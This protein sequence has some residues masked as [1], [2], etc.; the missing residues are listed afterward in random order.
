[1]PMQRRT[2][3]GRVNRPKVCFVGS[4]VPRACGIATFTSDLR[5][6]VANT[7]AASSVVALTNTDTGYDYPAEVALEIRQHQL[8]DY[9]LAAEYINDSDNDI[10]CLQHEFGIF[11]G[12]EG[13]YILDLLKRLRKPIVTTLHTV[14]P[15]PTPAYR[16]ALIGVASRSDHLVV[17]NSRAIPI[18]T[19]VYGIDP[20][21]I[22]MIHHGVPD[23]P[24]IDPE[25]F[26]DEFGVT[27]RT[28]LLTFGLLNRNKGIEQVLDALPCVAQ[29]HPDV[30]YL[31]LGATHPEVKRHDGE[32][33][34]YYLEQLVR[35]RGIGRHVQFH[36]YFV[37][38]DQL[39][40][41]IGASDIYIT[42]YRARDQIVSGTLAYAVGMGKAVVSTPYLYALELLS[43]DR[44]RLVPF[45]DRAAME[46]ALI[47][48]IEARAERHRMRKRAYALGRDMTWP[49]VGEAYVKLFESVVS[50][51]HHQPARIAASRGRQSYVVPDARLDHLIALT[52]CT[53]II[54]HAAWE[55]PDRRF[56]YSTDDQAR[57]LVVTLMHYQQHRDDA[58]LPLAARYLSFLQHA[59]LPNG[60]FHNF[61]DYRRRFTDECGSEDTLGRAIWGLGTAVAL[62][63]S[64]GMRAVARG[65]FERATASLAVTYPRAMA[66]SICGL[67]AFLQR[68][69]G[70]VQV[71]RLLIELADRL[72]ALYESHASTDWSWFEDTLTY[73]N[74]KL[75]EAVLLAWHVTGNDRYR[76]VGLEAL[77]FLIDATWRDG[78]FDFIG[79]RGWWPRGGKRSSD[80]QQPIEAG[81]TAAACALAWELTGEPRYVELEHAAVEWFLGR[82]R[83]NACLYD[84]TTGGC[85]DGLDAA[86]PNAN[87]GAES[88]ICCLLGLLTLSCQ[89]ERQTAPSSLVAAGHR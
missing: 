59:Q 53:G 76:D 81:Y 3:N 56:G 86:G 44:G 47:G 83:Y 57:A 5:A 88:V 72:T 29:A 80:G 54:Q 82:N 24:F 2:G 15:E 87:Q 45:D 22:S 40:R 46:E 68:Y 6:A 17:L 85:R 21:K 12:R 69:D 60:A 55:L 36:D 74:A 78:M 52:D 34:R 64:E 9:R 73:A 48:L 62:A 66:Y 38:L 67:H 50:G 16:E 7:G 89:R 71:R 20:C 30:V 25:Y 33:Y 63:P 42:P 43:D 10:V 27:G 26:K 49:V 79:N 84:Y 41:Y 31:V 39:C 13:R 75:P 37:S 32:E 28:V 19:D 18:L 8:A 77:D 4:Y 70:A 51:A 14:L 1:M 35:E 11:G 61:M 58:V 65:V 23:V